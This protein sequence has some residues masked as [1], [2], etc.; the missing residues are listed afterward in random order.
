MKKCPVCGKE[1]S[2]ELGYCDQDSTK[3][4]DSRP[5]VAPEILPL[6]LDALGEVERRVHM[7][8]RL[9]DSLR[10]DMAKDAYGIPSTREGEAQC[11]I[12]STPGTGTI[13]RARQFSDAVQ[14]GFNP[15]YNG[16]LPE[17][18]VRNSSPSSASRWAQSAISGDSSRSDWNV[19]PRCMSKL[20]AFLIAPATVSQSKSEAVNVE[21]ASIESRPQPPTPPKEP[22][23]KW[24]EFWK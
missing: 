13:V 19:C 22:Q 16:C 15:Y 10:V 1:F 6:M 17:S 11:D 23:K 7:D 20:S 5:Q 3:L 14:K 18:W 8:P 24:W 4:V 12:C 2:N 21:K 9:A